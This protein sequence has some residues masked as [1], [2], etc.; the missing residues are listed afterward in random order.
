M[1]NLVNKIQFDNPL[2]TLGLTHLYQAYKEA[3]TDEDIINVIHASFNAIEGNKIAEVLMY[4]FLNRTLDIMYNPLFLEM[5][6]T[7]EEHNKSIGYG[8]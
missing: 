5:L 1:A 2:K 6:F 7:I 4:D 8:N 3:S